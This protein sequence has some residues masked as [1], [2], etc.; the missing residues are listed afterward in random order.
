[1]KTSILS[2]IALVVLTFSIPAF[3]DNTN[4]AA[5]VSVSPTANQLVEKFGDKLDQFITAI[6]NKAG[7]AADHFYP[8]FVKQQR[9][10]GITNMS[11]ILIGIVFVVLLA[12]NGFNINKQYELEK[13]KENPS[14]YCDRYG[15]VEYPGTA[16]ASFILA[17]VITVV[18]VITTMAIGADT[19]GQIANPEYSAV[20]SLVSMVK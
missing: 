18:V 11:L 14:R 8:I 16:I 15:R 20:Q 4:T 1:M 13:A 5:T 9:I 19:I 3:A 6:A 17:A 7:V 10:I 2:L 12:R